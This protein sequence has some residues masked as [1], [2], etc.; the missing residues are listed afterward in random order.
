MIN[1]IIQ[2]MNEHK[3]ETKDLLQILE[4]QQSNFSRLTKN[5]DILNIKNAIR[6]ANSLNLSLD[7]I[8]K[9][10]LSTKIDIEFQNKF[11]RLKENDQ[12]TIINLINSLSEK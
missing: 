1:T 12:Q 7:F 6:L 4:M 11:N 9:E 5:K 2:I 3:L 8:Y 10:Y